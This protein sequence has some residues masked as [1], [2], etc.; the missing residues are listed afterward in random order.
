MDTTTLRSALDSALTSPYAIAV[1][2]E[3]ETGRYAGVVTADAILDQVR[4]RRS[5]SRMARPPGR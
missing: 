5:G 4:E 1:A 2:V 3:P